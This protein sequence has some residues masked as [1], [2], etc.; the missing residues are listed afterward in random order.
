MTV[1][2]PTFA[3]TLAFRNRI[4]SYTNQNISFFL[5]IILKIKMIKKKH[6]ATF[7]KI[8]LTQ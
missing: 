4:Y 1:Y 6:V 2:T 8:D 7:N 5:K 3:K